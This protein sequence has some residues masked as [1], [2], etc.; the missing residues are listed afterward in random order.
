MAFY[1]LI[2]L[3]HTLFQIQPGTDQGGVIGIAQRVVSRA[4]GLDTQHFHGGFQSLLRVGAVSLGIEDHLG[5][6]PAVGKGGVHVEKLQIFPQNTDV[7][8]AP[9]QEHNI[10]TAPIPEQLHGL[11]KGH[12]LVPQLILLDAG[13]LADPAVQ[14]PVELGPDQD[15][16]FVR[17][18]SGFRNT[19]RADL[20][21]LAPD[22]NGQHL[23]GG[24]RTGPRLI[25]F[26]IHNNVVH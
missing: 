1:S 24:R 8:E 11:R 17:N 7:V 19:H 9:G 22:L 2:I 14:M 18:F 12:A 25:P 16:K 3:C 23:L 13:E 4:R 26:H 5:I 6:I 10:L 15:L 20:D 21:D